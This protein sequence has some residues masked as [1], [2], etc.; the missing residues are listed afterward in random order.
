MSKS[1]HARHQSIL[2]QLYERQEVSAKALAR[3]FGVSEATVRRDL[4][5]LAATGQV[6]L[7]YG[8]A[9]LRPGTDYSYRSKATRNI[10]AKAIIGGL[11]ARLCMEGDQ[12]FL[13]SGTT[14]AAMAPHL[15]AKQGLSI[16]V[17]SARL[18]LELESVNTEVILIG[19]QYRHD[20]MDTVGPLAHT[21]LDGLHGYVCFLGADGLSMDHGVMAADVESS[22]LF[23]RAAQN[24][25]EVVLVA[26]HSKFAAASLC[27]VVGWDD[28]DTVVTDG[29]P[30][31]EWL[32]FFTAHEIELVCPELAPATA[33][34]AGIETQAEEQDTP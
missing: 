26:D 6:V 9:V 28:I 34:A 25:R 18:A 5:A 16:I 24:A 13:D 15:K 31:Q 8:G 20:R 14:C 7:S 11:A 27:R 17:N 10:E 12:I 3:V 33:G 4:R 23:R 32:D 29:A 22:Y 21:T 2:A 1:V 19:G 30:S